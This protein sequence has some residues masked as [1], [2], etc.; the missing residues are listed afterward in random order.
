MNVHTAV[1]EA[2]VTVHRV[3]AEYD[4]GEIAVQIKVTRYLVVWEYPKGYR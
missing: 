1:I 2:R 3:N 4:S